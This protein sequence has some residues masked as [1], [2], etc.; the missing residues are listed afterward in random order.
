[1]RKARIKMDDQT[2]WYHCFNRIAGTRNDFPFGR[3]EK[4]AFVRILKRCSRLYDVRVVGYQVMSNHFHLIV[5]VPKEQPAADDMCRRYAAFHENRKTIEPDSPECAQW[6]ERSRDI[7]WF[8]RHLQQLFTFW[9]NGSRPVRRRGTLW[10]D[11]YQHVI[12]QSGAAVWRCWNYVENNAVQAGMVKSAAE[13]RFGSY[14]VWRQTGAHPFSRNVKQYALP[15]LAAYMGIRSMRQLR[16]A[17]GRA[18]GEADESADLV[19]NR[20]R[21]WTRGLVIGT[22]RFVIQTMRQHESPERI[23]RQRMRVI[24]GKDKPLYTWRNVQPVAA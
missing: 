16:K 1:M 19:Q 12:L 8:M 10:A 24:P 21:I 11:R 6:Q 2:T 20:I 4:E 23:Q 7:S 13:Y 22:Q 9:Y 18:L 17:M 14:G 5:Q 3:A 15:M